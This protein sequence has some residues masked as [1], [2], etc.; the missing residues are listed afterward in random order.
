MYHSFFIG[1]FA[2]RWTDLESV[3]QSES[4]RNKIKYRTET[5]I[6]GI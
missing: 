1:S 6:C 5:H 2:E 4:I 3:I